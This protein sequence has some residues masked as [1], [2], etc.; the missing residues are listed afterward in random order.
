MFIREV[1]IRDISEIEKVCIHK[2][3]SVPVRSSHKIKPKQSHYDK[4]E[5]RILD[6]CRQQKE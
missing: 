1:G 3:L 6:L 2:V 5:G 4:L